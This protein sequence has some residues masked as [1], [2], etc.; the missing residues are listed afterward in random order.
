MDDFIFVFFI[1]IWIIGGIFSKLAQNKDEKRG[2]KS[3][4]QP[5]AASKSDIQDFLNSVKK[6]TRQTTPSTTGGT[7]ETSQSQSFPEAETAM[8]RQEQFEKKRT[9][10]AER[11]QAAEEKITATRKKAAAAAQM[12]AANTTA[13][14]SSPSELDSGAYGSPKKTAPPSVRGIRLSPNTMKNSVILSEIL[15]P[16]LSM[17]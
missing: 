2:N 16:P 7:T 6:K 12:S 8:Q 10:A 9:A 3:G 5:F 13:V 14:T 1:L 15:R 4:S 17:R 11:T